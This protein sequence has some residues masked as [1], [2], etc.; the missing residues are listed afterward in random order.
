MK[1]AEHLYMHDSMRR[2][3]D[4]VIRRLEKGKFRSS[5]FLIVLSESPQNQLEILDSRMLAQKAYPDMDNLIV[6]LAK[7]HKEAMDLVEEI[8]KEVYNETKG[9]DIRS[10]ILNQE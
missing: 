7:N 8:V 10:Y 6:G 5:V 9:T 3:K 1:Y 4:R 2:K